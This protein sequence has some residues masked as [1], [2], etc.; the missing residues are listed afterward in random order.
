VNGGKFTVPPG[1]GTKMFHPSSDFLLHDVG[2]GDGIVRSG[3]QEKAHRLRTLP[4][5]GV[6]T[7]TQLM[8]YGWPLADFH[9][10]DPAPRR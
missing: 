6:R 5:W 1:L 8:H 2:T 7:H 9:R 3:G 4:L 10:R